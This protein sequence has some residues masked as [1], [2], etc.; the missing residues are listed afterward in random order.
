MKRAWIAFAVT[1]ILVLPMRMIAVLSDLNPQTGFYSD[2]GKLVGAASVLLAAGIVLT[3]VLSAKGGIERTGTEPLKNVPAAASGALA[4]IFVLVQS[5]VGLNAGLFGDAAF[6][7]RIFSAVGILAGAVIL[8]AA[9]DL[10]TGFRTIGKHPLLALIP[11]L[12]ECLLIVVLFITYSAVVNLVE[13]VYH[14]FTVVF[15]LLFLFTQAKLLTGIESGKSGK[16][17]F[18]AGLPAALLAIAT[19]VPSCV[20]YFTAGETAGA[21]PVGLHL[22]NILLAVYILAFLSALQ[23]EPLPAAAEGAGNREPESPAPGENA[24]SPKQARE[25]S[26]SDCV[27]FLKKTCGDE[28]KFVGLSESPF[29]SEKDFNF[30]ESALK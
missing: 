13:D 25:D 5:V 7:Y 6:F 9:Y 10:A 8:V 3:A 15:L 19:G 26:L 4:G 14:T 18:A 30:Q 22:A 28:R 1:L 2:G 20:Q 16:M 11:P 27:A 23:H 21:V 12:W 17:I 29:Y 24:F